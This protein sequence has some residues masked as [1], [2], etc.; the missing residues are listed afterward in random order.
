MDCTDRKHSVASTRNSP[1]SI[2]TVPATEISSSTV[3]PS[4][5]GI[6]SCVTESHI[7]TIPSTAVLSRR[8]SVLLHST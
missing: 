4:V 3:L 6:C 1:S 8:G 7:N 2:S 5:H